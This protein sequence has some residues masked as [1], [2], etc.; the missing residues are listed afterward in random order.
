MGQLITRG[1]FWDYLDTLPM[2]TSKMTEKQLLSVKQ[3]HSDT[4]VSLGHSNCLY[5]D[6]IWF[7]NNM[8]IKK[9]LRWIKTLT[10]DFTEKNYSVD[11]KAMSTKWLFKDTGHELLTK[12]FNHPQFSIYDVDAL[13]MIIEFLY[14]GHKEILWNE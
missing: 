2:Q 9:E 12:V 4:I 7:E 3:A 6:D 14:N 10:E 13:Q 1:N 11:V 5:V 8:G